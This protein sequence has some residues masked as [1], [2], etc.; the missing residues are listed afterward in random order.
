MLGILGATIMN[1]MR[2][3]RL[4]GKREPSLFVIV[5]A[6][7]MIGATAERTI[8]SDTPNKE[9][10]ER[11]SRL[12]KNIRELV[13]THK[14]ADRELLAAFDQKS[15]PES[16]ISE[17][18]RVREQWI[19]ESDLVHDSFVREYKEKY[20]AD[21]IVLRNEL[22]RRLPK[23][24]RQSQVSG[25]YQHPTNVLGVEAIADHLELLAKSLPDR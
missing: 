5:A 24:L 23:D 15:R 10:K 8:Y 13:Y 18:K 21:A 3:G 17:R 1:D 14:N 9:L 22:H 4:G 20:W 6:V 7:I 12:V 16:R 2:I 19:R 11:A 25:I